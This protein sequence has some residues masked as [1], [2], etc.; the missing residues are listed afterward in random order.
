MIKSSNSNELE[1]VS[2]T[3]PSSPS[4]EVLGY[5][6]VYN[7]NNGNS[8]LEDENEQINYTNMAS[9]GAGIG[10]SLTD[11]W[12]YV[13]NASNNSGSTPW[14][15]PSTTWE[16]V[17]STPSRTNGN[18]SNFSKI[19]SKLMDQQLNA[20]FL[21][22]QNNQQLLNKYPK[23]MSNENA[24]ETQYSNQAEQIQSK[25][26]QQFNALNLNNSLSL[27]LGLGSNNGSN[28]SNMS[29][30]DSLGDMMTVDKMLLHSANANSNSTSDAQKKANI[31]MEQLQQQQQLMNL[32]S[33]ATNNYANL[34]PNEQ[35]QA[36]LILENVELISSKLT[37]PKQNFDMNNLLSANNANQNDMNNKR[38]GV[39][40][41][42]FNQ[43]SSF[44][45][46]SSSP[47]PSSQSRLN[48]APNMVYNNLNDMNKSLNHQ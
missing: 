11:S 22:L 20:E 43:N 4:E 45:H 46:N 16:N 38:Q 24:N 47:P 36:R 35:K 14:S 44:I 40:A 32:I 29:E 19:P 18:P 25:Q 23:N 9:N 12:N 30:S 17:T 7:V 21:K 1:N 2:G 34:N 33:W 37:N 6:D 5:Q 13:E 10:N 28:M 3:S 39:S 41:S 31:N 48:S 27:P 8:L 15:S 26:A 42:F